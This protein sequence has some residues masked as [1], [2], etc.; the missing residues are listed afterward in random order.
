MGIR[1]D[2]RIVIVKARRG[3]DGVAEFER[4]VRDLLGYP[5]DVELDF[6]F[7]C[8]APDATDGALSCPSPRGVRRGRVC[9]GLTAVVVSLNSDGPGP[10]C[11]CPATARRSA[12]I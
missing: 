3:P 6:T 11:S 5:Q 4:K 1:V 10:L 8:S 7:S 2:G 12:L 9:S